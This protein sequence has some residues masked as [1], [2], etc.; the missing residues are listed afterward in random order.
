MESLLTP[1]QVAD[2]LGV[3]L[4]TI[5]QWT[6]MEFIP[7]VKL[8]R[9]LRFREKDLEQWVQSKARRGRRTYRVNVAL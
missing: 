4:G 9:F 2:K 6:H 5:Y 8:G 1:Q 3:K 7:H